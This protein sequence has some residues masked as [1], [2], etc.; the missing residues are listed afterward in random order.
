M[1]IRRYIQKQIEADL[2]KG[3]AL[4]LF[5]ARQVG[6]TTL[7]NNLLRPELD[8]YLNADQAETRDLLETTNLS[9]LS[10]FL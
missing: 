5:G 10:S 7:V 3:K 6:K 1:Q 9:R 4:L 8:I 2:G